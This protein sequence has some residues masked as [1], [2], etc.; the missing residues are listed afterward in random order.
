MT[1]NVKDR[2]WKKINSWRGRP[3]SRAGK[4]VMIKSV[5]QSIPSYIMSLFILPDGIVSDI[6]KMLNSFWWGGGTNHNCIRW[7]A[8]DKLTGTKNE[9]GLGFRDLKSFNLAMVAKRGW[10]L[11][12][13]PHSLVSIIFKAKY[14]P[15]STF[16]EASL[17]NNPSF[18]WRSVWQ[19]RSLL[20]LGCRWSIGDGRNIPVMG[21]LWLRGSREGMLI[22]PQTQGV[23]AMSVH[24]LLSPNGKL[25]NAGLISEMFGADEA[26]II[27]QV[28]L[29]DEVQEDKW[30]WGE[31]QNG[32]YNVRTG[33]RVWRRE[34]SRSVGV[35][36]TGN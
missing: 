18:V 36:V 29:V 35:G 6:E 28:P 12:S 13:K 17:G 4:E 25:W 21:S 14:F 2:V 1:F 34:S 16:F 10:L 22:G 9:G 20:S 26:K 3:L 23:Y 24:E 8:W 5:L 33:Y 32:E 27:L 11:L 19:A 31:E 30:I 7:M 15:N